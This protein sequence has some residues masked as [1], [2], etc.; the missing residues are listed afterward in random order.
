MLLFLLLQSF[1]NSD[2]SFLLYTLCYNHPRTKES[3]YLDILN[4]CFSKGAHLNDRNVLGN[5][6]LHIAALTGNAVA[7]KFLLNN[8]AFPNSIN[9]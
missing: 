6:C 9:K 2:G 1:Q 4:K 7:V 8:K 5:T 3:L